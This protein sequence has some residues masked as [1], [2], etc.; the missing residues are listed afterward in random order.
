VHRFWFERRARYRARLLR[1]A[2]VTPDGRPASAEV[3]YLGERGV[4]EG[5]FGREVLR[6]AL[7]ASAAAGSETVLPLALAHRGDWEW[8]SDAPL[9]VLVGVRFEPLDG[10][11][12]SELRVPLPRRVAPGGRLEMTLPVRWPEA[13]GRY[14][15]VVD[16]VLEG[17]AWFADRVGEPLAAGEVTVTAAP[18]G[19]GAP[20]RR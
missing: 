2:L 12:P 3:R 5:G 9:P 7:P 17:I 6:A 20:L 18:A 19:P 16:L 15:V 8:D 13:P 10:G 1:L 14:R 4:P 11:A